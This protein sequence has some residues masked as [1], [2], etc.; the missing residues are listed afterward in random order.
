[1]HTYEE[2][3]LSLTKEDFGSLKDGWKQTRCPLR[4]IIIQV[5]HYIQIETAGTLTNE[6]RT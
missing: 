6:N 2:Q 5:C 3:N 1:M 4:E